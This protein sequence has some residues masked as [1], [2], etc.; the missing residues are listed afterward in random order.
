MLSEA[1][2]IE[3]GRSRLA[4]R[5]DFIGEKSLSQLGDGNLAPHFVALGSRVG[6]AIRL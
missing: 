4:L 6:A 2:A 1:K 3:A 5:R